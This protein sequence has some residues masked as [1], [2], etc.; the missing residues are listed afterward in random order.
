MDGKM[1]GLIDG[2]LDGGMHSLMVWL[3]DGWKEGWIDCVTA[4]VG[5]FLLVLG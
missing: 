2:W 4:G 3:I 5:L 1:H